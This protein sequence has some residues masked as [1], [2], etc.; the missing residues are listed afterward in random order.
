MALQKSDKPDG[1]TS[2]PESRMRPQSS[3][4]EE[5]SA[6]EKSGRAFRTIGEVSELLDLPQHVLRFWETRFTQI[7]PL[8]R[9]GNRRYYRP[10]DIELLQAIKTLLYDEGIT[11]KGV[12][13]RFREQGV[14]TVLADVAGS[15]GTGTVLG[16]VQSDALPSSDVPPSSVQEDG[17]EATAPSEDRS[18]KADI[19]A[20]VLADILAELKALRA[21]LD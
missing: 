9:G 3:I 21:M 15:S 5:R 12:Q 4:T 13:K 18:R 2:G 11:I 19:P 7:R 6:T 10:G 1:P 8:K 16:D 17:V 20:D 14:K